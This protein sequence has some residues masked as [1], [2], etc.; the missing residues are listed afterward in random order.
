MVLIVVTIDQN[1]YIWA[2]WWGETGLE[3]LVYI[4]GKYDKL[5]GFLHFDI[6]SLFSSNLFKPVF[7]IPDFK[8]NNLHLDVHCSVSKAVYTAQVCEKW[9]Q[10]CQFYSFIALTLVTM[11][12]VKLVTKSW[13]NFVLCD[14]SWASTSVC[15]LTSLPPGGGGGTQMA[16]GGIGS[17]QGV[18]AP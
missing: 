2:L 16:R 14:L 6:N 8:T 12:Q 9:K 3:S 13:I 1:I 5:S 11:E 4:F 15:D 7:W 10:I 17:A 18:K